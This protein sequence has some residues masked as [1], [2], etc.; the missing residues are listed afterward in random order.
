MFGR[1][2]RHDAL[3]LAIMTL[4]TVLTWAGFDIYQAYRQVEIPQVLQR[5]ISPLNPNLDPQ[6]FASL[7]ERRFISREEFQVEYDKALS[8]FIEATKEAELSEPE[9]ATE[10]AT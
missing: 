6:I 1:N 4:I 7:K 2:L 8:E 9:E 10:S 3:N 5:Q